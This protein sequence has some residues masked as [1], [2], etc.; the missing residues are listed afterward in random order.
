[1]SSVFPF[2]VTCV[3][4]CV[5]MLGLPL[6]GDVIGISTSSVGQ[7]SDVSIGGISPYLLIS[8]MGSIC[9]PDSKFSTYYSVL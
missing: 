9:L 1:M 7:G 4:D 2:C 3:F 6:R 5:C 8:T